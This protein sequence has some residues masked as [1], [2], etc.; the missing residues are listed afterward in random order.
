MEARAH[1]WCNDTNGD[2]AWLL[3]EVIKKTDD[4]LSLFQV[5]KTSNKFT[6]PFLK[7]EGKYKGVELVSLAES[8]TN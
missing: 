7:D 2:E 4:E 8:K 6:Q 5:D 3:V 1:V